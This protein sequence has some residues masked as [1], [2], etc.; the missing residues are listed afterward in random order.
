MQNQFRL[1]DLLARDV[2]PQWFE[3]VAVVQ[4]ICRQLRAEPREASGFPGPEDILIA[5]GGSVT[6]AGA[7]Q[8]NPVE[9]AAHVLGLMLGHDVPVR[10]RLSISQATGTESG[11]A[12]LTEFS[13]ALAYFE[14]PNPEL[15]VEAFR[16]RALTAP[17]RDITPRVQADAPPVVE[18]QSV[19]VP[20]P[21]R[22]RISRLA[23]IAAAVS[24]LAC[25]AV[26]LT[27]NRVISMLTPK[28][29]IAEAAEGTPTTGQSTTKSASAHAAGRQ[30]ERVSMTAPTPRRTDTRGAAATELTALSPKSVLGPAPKLQVVATTLSFAYPTLSASE[31]V[32]NFGAMSVSNLPT[33]AAGIVGFRD[34]VA[35]QA[36][37][38]TSDR[39]YSQADPQVTLPLSVYPKFPTEA[40]GIPGPGR[41]TLEL[42]IAVDGVVERVRMLTAPRNIHE[43]MLLSAAKAWRFEPARMGGHPV[44]FRQLITLT[45]NP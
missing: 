9:T 21:R 5:P 15:I 28:I 39:V 23:V 19:P 20:Q 18:K 27:D 13:E 36:S 31:S 22:R 42:T 43:F 33:S 2:V 40:L 38:E 41:T 7:S 24:A 34:G 1:D 16:Q 4:L 11:F 29:V 26:W 32:S 6:I 3:G 12:S 37:E 35:V 25:A 44:R 45:S 10:L 14:R 17:R 8:G 30:N